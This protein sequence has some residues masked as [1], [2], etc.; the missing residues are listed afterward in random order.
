[1]SPYVIAR[2]WSAIGAPLANHLWQSTVFA[3]TIAVLTLLLRRNHAN[4]RYWLWLLTSAK[5]LFPFSLLVTM[6]N[7]LSWVKLPS[8]AQSRFFWVIQ[9]VGRPFATAQSNAAAL[10]SFTLLVHFL[11]IVL[12]LIWASGFL[13]VVF[14]WFSRWRRLNEAVG[15]AQP[16]NSGR[17]L[18]ILRLEESAGNVKPVRLVTSHSAVEPGIF[19]IFRPVLLLPFGITHHLT[20]EQ[21]RAI[22]SHELCHVR[23]RD[24]LTAALHMVIEAIFWFHPLIW[25]IGARLIDERERACD[26]EVLRLG[27]NPQAYAESI[28]KICELYVESPALCA[29]GVTGSNLKKRIEVIMCNN[30]PLRLDLS[31]KLLLWAAGTVFL[32]VPVLTGI[33]NPTPSHAQAQPVSAARTASK[34]VLGDLRIEGD[35]HDRE[36]VRERVLRAWKDRT[37]DDPKELAA[38]V[39]GVGI[40]KDIQDRGY[41]RM[42]ASE[43]M[44]QSLG[45][46]D[47]KERL[48]ISTSV[49][50]GLQYRLG[51]FI[52]QNA[53]LGRGL[54]IPPET[55]REQFHIR[56]GE[57]FNP[58]EIRSGLEKVQRLY[59]AKGYGE[60]FPEP[61][62]SIDDEQKLINLTIRITEKTTSK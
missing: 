56:S 62:T 52:V 9:G 18:N 16:V 12:F 4:T 13:V 36:G 58:S 10:S 8:T 15:S 54:I 40:R 61:A 7:W 32:T 41:F 28:L 46:A 35:I 42:V 5:L 19:G 17:A 38:E 53:L 27:A 44:S 6:G 29:S 51:N 21:L 23:R 25:W 24:N 22:L 3:A 26:E 59:A 20:D 30:T 55:L 57:L 34:F 39:V 60:T 1:M 2:W 47:G 43:P 48:L 50:E 31:K 14:Y 33:L 45:I 11:P 49:T 37:Y